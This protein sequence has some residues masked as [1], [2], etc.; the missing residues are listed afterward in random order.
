MKDIIATGK[1][2]I[3][4]SSGRFQLI[5]MSVNS[6]LGRHVCARD[7]VEDREMKAGYMEGTLPQGKSILL[8][9]KDALATWETIRGYISTLPMFV[10]ARA[11]FSIVAMKVGKND[12]LK[13]A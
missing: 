11:H 4:L 5:S 12:G 1:G 10:L 2:R 13:E 6:F 9:A 8:N 7:E 3:D